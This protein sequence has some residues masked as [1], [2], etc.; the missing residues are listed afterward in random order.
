MGGLGAQKIITG[1]TQVALLMMD[2]GM[3]IQEA[4]NFPRIHDAYGTLTYEGRMN[5]Q[6]VQELEKMG[7]E[8]KNGGEWLEYP[9]IQGVTMAEDGTLRGG[10]DPRRDGK[11]LGF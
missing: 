7:H 3:D 1:I 8:M 10:A 2:Y 6:V 9:C 5:P 11:A 4:I